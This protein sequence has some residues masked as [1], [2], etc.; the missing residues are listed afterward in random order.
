MRAHGPPS[1]QRL[2]TCQS[3]RLPKLRN[4][5]KVCLKA[6]PQCE[7]PMILRADGSEAGPRPRPTAHA[8]TCS[9]PA[10]HVRGRPGHVHGRWD[11]VTPWTQTPPPIPR[12]AVFWREEGGGKTGTLPR[13]REE[14]GNLLPCCYFRRRS[15]AASG[16]NNGEDESTLAHRTTSTHVH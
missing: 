8:H 1:G 15:A 3:T 14:E 9:R 10:V 7:D 12:Q 13:G 6:M 5:P 11:S 2:H 16:T 4:P